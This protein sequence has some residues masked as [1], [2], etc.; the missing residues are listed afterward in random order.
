MDRTMHQRCS[1]RSNYT[2]RPDPVTAQPIHVNASAVKPALSQ[3]EVVAASAAEAR[4]FAD[5]LT[6][7][8]EADA[9]AIL[10][11]SEDE[12]IEASQPNAVSDPYG[13]EPTAAAAC[14]GV[15]SA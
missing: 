14:Q 13:A 11:D 6:E 15:T 10:T 2:C 9:A 3:A 7:V 8:A 5:K 4:D 1:D 12:L